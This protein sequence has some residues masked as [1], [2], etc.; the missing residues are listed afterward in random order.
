MEALRVIRELIS[1]LT[2]EEKQTIRIYLTTFYHKGKSVRSV[3]LFDL[4]V[5][6]Q[7]S[8]DGSETKPVELET[9]LYGQQ[10]GAN[11]SRLLYRL[12]EKILEALIIDVNVN[13]EGAYDERAKVNIEVRKNLTQIQILRSRGLKGIAQTILTKVIEQ[14]KKYEL[15]EEL[16][17]A[18]RL[19][20]DVHA[21][22]QGDK[23]QAK[24]LAQH[25]RYVHAMNAVLRAEMNRGKLHAELDFR[26]G[27]NA[28]VE[29]LKGMLD[30]MNADYRKTSSSQ[31]GF[32][33]FYVLT[34][35]YQLLG[36]Y[37]SA[38]KALQDNLKLLDVSPG[39]YTAIRV[40]NVQL[41]L[42]D[43]DL[44]LGEYNRCFKVATQS[45]RYFKPTSFNHTQAI[46][47]MF[48]AQ[49]YAGDYSLAREVLLQLL[50]DIDET[51]G[52]LY[53]Q[54]KRLYL[55][56][57]TCFMLQDYQSALKLTNNFTN[58]ISE[59]REGWNLGARILT[60]LSLIEIGELDMAAGKISILKNFADTL[61]KSLV[62][63]RVQ[64]TCLLLRK[65]SNAAFI[66]K[67][68][69]QKDKDRIEQLQKTPWVPKSPEMVIFD[70]WYMAKM[71][72]QPFMQATIVAANNATTKSNA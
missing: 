48:Y 30:E 56:A 16:L 37:K 72:K 28:K 67:T 27:Q 53:R 9:I 17:M 19:Q 23:H 62:S 25:E 55:L 35:Y 50:P 61:D 69:Y 33:Y 22:D 58:P 65:L 8:K 70:Q 10:S 43:N 7:K 13:R 5:A 60:I 29:W 68:A 63:P 21:E 14:T 11:F 20:I 26:T 36:D 51:T 64:I 71:L 12:R 1:R 52:V 44:Y 45:Q 6:E 15:F 18:L 54:G 39:I 57:C 49:Y 42:A 40:G 59:D 38:R 2:E 34:Q 41:N 24:L 3:K 47:L 4:L 32:Y 66:F 31:V 46:E